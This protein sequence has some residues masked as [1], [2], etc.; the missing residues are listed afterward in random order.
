MAPDPTLKTRKTI[1][2]VA[3]AVL[4]FVVVA[5]LLLIPSHRDPRDVHAEIV[6]Y[7][8]ANRTTS[9]PLAVL[10][11]HP[12]SRVCLVREYT[13]FAHTAA[14]YGFLERRFHAEVD[15]GYI[16][17]LMINEHQATMQET[18]ASEMDYDWLYEP[19]YDRSG[20]ERC[21]QGA[22]IQLAYKAV[23]PSFEAAKVFI[24]GGRIKAD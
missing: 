1:V 23:E 20:K 13:R 3:A 24:R 7:L 22:N 21:I 11:K 10:A 5:L 15:E 8:K 17:L 14:Q 9:I 6:T 16:G 19:P 2:R 4:L 18:W 12:V